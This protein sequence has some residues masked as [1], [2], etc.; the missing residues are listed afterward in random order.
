[1]HIAVLEDNVADRKQLERLLD[2]E[3]DRRIQTTGNLYIDTYGAKDALLT[4]PLKQ[5]DFFMINMEGP[6]SEGLEVIKN[7]KTRG[8]SVPVCL[9]RKEDE[10]KDNKDIPENLMFIEKPIK[11]A[12][13]TELIGKAISI[14][15]AEEAKEARIKQE[16]LEE[17]IKNNK[18]KIAF[19]RIMNKLF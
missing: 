6:V 10:L 18:G 17:Y 3:S 9:M 2:R 1:M 15:E 16:Q 14:K 11:V 4:A 13:L 5:Y 8:I 19:K 12:E 7:L